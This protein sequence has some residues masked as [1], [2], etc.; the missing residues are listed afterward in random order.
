MKE[1]A[2]T[3]NEVLAPQLDELADE[4]AQFLFS[5]ARILPIDPVE[6]FVLAIG[7]IVAPLRATDFVAG[8]QH[9][10]ALGRSPECCAF[11]VHAIRGSPD[12]PLAPRLRSSSWGS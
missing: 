10:R 6:L 7:I 8:E 9:G 1:A 12:R 5:R 11:A 3:E 2:S 4:I